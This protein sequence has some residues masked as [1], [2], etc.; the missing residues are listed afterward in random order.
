MIILDPVSSLPATL[1]SGMIS[2]IESVM[3]RA[4]RVKKPTTIT[5]RFVPDTVIR[6]LNKRFRKKDRPTDVLSFHA[7]EPPPGILPT[8][9]TLG[10]IV[11]APA[12]ARREAK[13]RSIPPEE[14]L[15]RLIV[16]GILHLSGY[17]HHTSEEEARMFALQESCV[18]RLMHV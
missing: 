7:P 16:H 13:R 10:D 5:L 4:L 1:P 8:E 17:D 18:E 14:E 15:A 11:I 9:Y 3:T 12:Y 6:A 2:R